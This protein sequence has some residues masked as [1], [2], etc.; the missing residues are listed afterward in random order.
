MFAAWL[1]TRLL[2]Q[3]WGGGFALG[4]CSQ[5]LSSSGVHVGMDYIRGIVVVH[6]STSKTA[7]ICLSQFRRQDVHTALCCPLWLSGGEC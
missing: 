7:T 1:F 2:I 5:V 6:I 4:A 3:G